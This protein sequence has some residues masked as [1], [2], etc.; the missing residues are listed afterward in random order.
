[1]NEKLQVHTRVRR[2]FHYLDDFQKGIIRV[3]AFQREFVWKIKDKLE[4]FDSIKNG[5]PIGSILFWRPGAESDGEFFHFEAEKIGSYYIPTRTAE[6]FFI[7]DG[8]QRISTLFGCLVNPYETTLLRDNEEWQ[9]EYNFIYNLRE[10]KFEYTKKGKTTDLE[11]YKVPLYKLVDSKEFFGF[12]KQLLKANLSDIEVQK[13]IARYENLSARL[14]DYQLPSI[15]IVGGTAVEAVD[16]FSRVNSTGVRISDDWKISA[17]SFNPARNFRLGTEIDLLLEDLKNYNFGTIKRNL[18]LQCIIN[19]FGKVFFDQSNSKILEELAIRGDFID[20]TRAT[21]SSIKKAVRFL[22]EEL[23]VLNSKLLPYNN[24]LIFIT[25]FFAKSLNP[26]NES[27]VA[28]KR[29]FWI[30]S[31]SGYFTI[32][33]LSKQRLAYNE[34]QYFIQNSQH[35][36]VYIDKPGKKFAVTKIPIRIS[37]GS[38]RAKSLALLMLNRIKEHFNVVTEVSDFK[39][40]PLF[41]TDDRDIDITTENQ[42]VV[43]EIPNGPKSGRL[44]E[45]TAWLSSNQ[46]LSA[47]FISSDVK[48]AYQQGENFSEILEKRKREIIFI[49]KLFVEELDMIY[50]ES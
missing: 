1:M 9:R 3:P 41:K 34:F 18:I 2:L 24:Q 42:V 13:Y 47:F 8:Y 22:H 40:V 26:T 31:Y 5:Y 6:H 20:I 49:E 50:E 16:I 10:D 43:V 21:L 25:D 37:M 39:I 44:K 46:D 35:D 12:Q 38:V 29:W 36:P 23:W 28:L 4:L 19:S 14:V 30:T 11:I 17:L 15:D 32:Y 48:Q 7:L 45:L 27:L 33:N